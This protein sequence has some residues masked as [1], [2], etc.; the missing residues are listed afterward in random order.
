MSPEDVIGLCAVLAT[1][2]VV[3]AI[4]AS[5]FKHRATL[6]MRQLELNRTAPDNGSHGHE[7]V[8]DRATIAKLEQRLRVLERIAV[9]HTNLLA[10]EIEQ[11]R[12]TEGRETA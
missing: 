6:R 11:L 2:I 12:I 10:D 8:E 9:D 1:I 7:R 4:I 3:S 5:T